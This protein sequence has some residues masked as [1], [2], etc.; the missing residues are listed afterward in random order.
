MRTK[1]LVAGSVLSFLAV[2]LLVSIGE[3]ASPA[4]ASPGLVTE[5]LTGPLT[6]E[7]LANDLVGGGLT[8]S[9]LTFSGAD[10]AAGRFSGG[11]GI[12]G[13][14]SGIILSSGDIANVVGPNVEDGITGDNGLPGD[15]DLDGLI[16]GFQTFDATV[17]EFD[18]IPD[19]DMVSFRYV[20]ASEEYN[21]Y[22][23]TEYNDVFAFI[24]NGVNCATVSGDPVSVNT[25]NNGNPLP[26]EDPTPHHPELYINNDLDDGGGSID[27][28]MDG[29]TT[30]LACQASVNPGV[31]NHIKLAIADSGDHILDANVLLEA[32]SFVPGT[33]V[34][35]RIGSGTVTPGGSIALDLDALDVPSG[36]IGSFTIEVGYD[37][38]LLD[39]IACTPDPDGILDFADCSPDYATGVARC[40]GVSIT[41]VSG[42]ELTLCDVTFEADPATSPG[43]LVP[44]P[45]NCVVL[46][47]PAGDPIPCIPQN[48]AV[49]IGLLGDVNCD[50]LVNVVDA[51]FILQY[52]VGLRV[53]SGGCPLPPGT[54]NVAACDAN[55]DGL[56]NVVDAMCILQFE[57]GIP[58]SHCPGLPPFA[59][60]Q[61]AQEEVGG[62]EEAKLEGG[63]NR[64]P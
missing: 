52:E 63:T 7:D 11:T 30:L 40:T 57:V 27:T 50:G 44:L 36:S 3:N 16:P 13:F 29:L 2:L 4:S 17:L 1:R 39:A 20:F 34:V 46:T 19:D 59:A 49:T 54:L 15:A 6:P 64:S 47:D 37:P 35:V 58:V 43:T 26:G 31:P 51:L 21:E 10:V 23:N 32:G 41:G 12:I 5:D 55:D 18:F 22:V 14:E 45:V 53:D 33:P 25:I 61:V 42:P 48:G 24:V 9:N 8:I 60:V 62:P 28:E 56:C 38:A